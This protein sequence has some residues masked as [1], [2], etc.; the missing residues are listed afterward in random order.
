MVSVVDEI[1]SRPNSASPR[2]LLKIAA[3]G[4][5]GTRITGRGIAFLVPIEGTN[6]YSG[7]FLTNYGTKKHERFRRLIEAA[8]S[9]TESL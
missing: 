6:I 4:E 5:P 8:I 7:T 1:A 9:G 2:R 3:G